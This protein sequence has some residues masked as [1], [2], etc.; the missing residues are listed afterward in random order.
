MRHVYEFAAMVSMMERFTE[1]NL[2]YTEA[3]DRLVQRIVDA[4]IAGAPKRGSLSPM[5]PRAPLCQAA[6]AALSRAEWC[7][8]LRRW[9]TA[10][11]RGVDYDPA[12]KGRHAA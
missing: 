2:D 9:H 8:K 12:A 5:A 10:A 1:P 4:Q 3:L 11:K 7:F 6:M